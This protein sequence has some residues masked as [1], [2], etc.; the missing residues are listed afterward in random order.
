MRAHQPLDPITTDRHAFATQRQPHAP[1]AVA[2]RVGRVHGLDLAEPPF[3]ADR[4]RRSLA[5][6]R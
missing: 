1:I 5:V 3:V 6:A 2:V 4:S